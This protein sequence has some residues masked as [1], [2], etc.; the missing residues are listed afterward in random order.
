MKAVELLELLQYQRGQKLW[1]KKYEKTFIRERAREEKL[2][3]KEMNRLNRILVEDRYD[4]ENIDSHKIVYNLENGEATTLY[5]LSKKTKLPMTILNNRISNKICVCKCP[6]SYDKNDTP[7]FYRLRYNDIR[8]ALYRC[9]ELNIALSDKEWKEYFNDPS[10]KMA[11]YGQKGKKYKG[12][13]TFK[14]T[15][16]YI[17]Y[18]GGRK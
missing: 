6:Y 13:Y 5:K 9:E 18:I 4:K 12:K 11:Y 1:L 2:S 3:E 15:N 8:F 17:D 10:I 14:G 16:L 7:L